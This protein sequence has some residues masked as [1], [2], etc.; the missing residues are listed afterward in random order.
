[1][2]NVSDNASDIEAIKDV[3]YRYLRALDTKHWD[4]FAA[5]LTEDI[6]GDYGSNP[7][8]SGTLRFTDRAALVDYMSTS[9][10]AAIITEHRVDHPQITFDGP[11]DASGVWY[12]QDRVIAA[13][14]NFML[15]GAAFYRDRYRRTADG[16]R[17]CAT[18]YDRTYEAT[19]S[20]ENLGFH[21]KAGPALNI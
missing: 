9:L 20:T 7:D 14:F 8:G 5:T 16:W 2:S 18:G 21:L 17:I 11:D 19:M 1:M 6:D 12:L 3:K 10:G 13:D 4:D 15:I